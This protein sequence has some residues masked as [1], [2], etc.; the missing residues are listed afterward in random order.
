MKDLTLSVVGVLAIALGI[1][2]AFHWLYPR[3]DMTSELA[4]LFVFVAIAL[5]LGISK[6]LSL[7]QKP[8]TE[9]DK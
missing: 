6:V 3:V 7:R 5:K 4:G 9:G 1:G 8:R 2:L